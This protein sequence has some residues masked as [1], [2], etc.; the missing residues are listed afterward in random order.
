MYIC[1]CIRVVACTCTDKLD[2]LSRPTGIHKLQYLPIVKMTYIFSYMF[3]K[4]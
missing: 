4:I 1:T 2:K 3:V